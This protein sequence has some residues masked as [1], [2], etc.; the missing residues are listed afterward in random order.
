MFQPHTTKSECELTVFTLGPAT[1]HI[2]VDVHSNII[3]S[4]E[5][6]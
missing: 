4:K 6:C 1:V 5:M 2:N 3:T